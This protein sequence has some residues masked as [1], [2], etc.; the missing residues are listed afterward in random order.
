VPPRPFP[1]GLRDPDLLPPPT[2]WSEIVAAIWAV[3]SIVGIP[4]ALRRWRRRAAG[5]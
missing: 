2:P 4:W 3:V 5:L 1:A